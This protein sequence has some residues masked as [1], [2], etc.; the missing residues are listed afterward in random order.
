MAL[1]I[2]SYQMASQ[3]IP[4]TTTTI[5]SLSHS[6][7]HSLLSIITM[8]LGERNF[9]KWS[10]Q[11]QSTLAGNGLFGFFDGSQVAPPRYALT[12]EDGITNE[13]TA[14]YK[15]WKQTHMALL[16]LLMATLDE[17]IVD[18]IIGYKTSKQAG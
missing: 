4:A 12:S 15:A 2:E 5:P 9:I 6:D 3:S 17:D 7:V 8:R 14:T 10:F 1:L 16:S 18:V 11:F 13:E